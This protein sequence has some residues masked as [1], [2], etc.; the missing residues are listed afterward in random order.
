MRYEAILLDFYGTLVAGD[1]EVI[2]A[3]CA[4]LTSSDEVRRAFGNRWFQLFAAAC[5]E[6]HGDGFKTQRTLAATS[7]SIAMQEFS[8]Q[9]DPA[10]ALAPLYAYWQHPP[11]FA[12]SHQFLATCPLP[13]CIVSNID[14]TDILSAVHHHGWQLPSLVTS[15]SARAYK[16]RAEIFVEALALLKLNP[17]SVLH[18]GDSLSAD[19]QGAQALGMDTVWLNRTDRSLPAGQTEPTF[20]LPNL[21]ELLKQLISS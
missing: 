13:I 15:E 2:G 10:M 6:A 4:Q 14:N 21:L 8:L 7:L 1:D 16:P 9:A 18:V 5:R 12:E 20:I 3:I 11:D 17:H 19:I